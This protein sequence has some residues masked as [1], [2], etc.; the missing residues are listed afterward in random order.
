MSTRIEQI[1]KY[2]VVDS[3]FVT[4]GNAKVK[5]LK[6]DWNQSYQYKF[7]GFYIYTDRYVQKY[8]CVFMHRLVCIYTY[9]LALFAESA[10]KQ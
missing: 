3:Q 4:I 8:N 2:I 9:F 1:N 5:P 6:F 10:W 7:M